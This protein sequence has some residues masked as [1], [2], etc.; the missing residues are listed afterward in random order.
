MVPLSTDPLK[1]AKR[2]ATLLGSALVLV[3]AVCFGLYVWN[4]Q[5]KVETLEASQVTAK[6][7]VAAAETHRVGVEVVHRHETAIKEATN[8]AL[9]RNP[10]YRDGVVPSDV[11]DILRKRPDSK[12]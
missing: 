8:D 10:E 6:A 2:Y 7:D 11:A 9:N 4:L 5:R 3:T 12:P 1:S